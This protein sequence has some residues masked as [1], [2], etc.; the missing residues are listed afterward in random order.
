[1]FFIIGLFTSFII[2]LRIKGLFT[3]S[4]IIPAKEKGKFKFLM[5]IKK[6]FGTFEKKGSR[7]SAPMVAIVLVAKGVFCSL[8]LISKPTSQTLLIK[9]VI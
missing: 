4:F 5:K 1:M 7:L 6:L 2:F 3:N 8:L 9:I